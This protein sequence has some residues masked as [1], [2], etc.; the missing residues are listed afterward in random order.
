[1]AM[2][3]LLD[4]LVWHTLFGP[5]ARYAAGTDTARRYAPGFPPIIGFSDV[6]NPDFPSLIPYTETGEHLY[7]DGWAGAVPSGWRIE[8]ESAMRTMMW[9]ASMPVADDVPEAVL[10]GSQHASAV[11]ELTDLIRP[12]PFGPR[13]IELGEYIGVFDGPRLVAMVGGRLCAGGFGEIGSV[14]T[15]PDFRGRGLARRL[16]VSL[17]RR[18]MQRGETPVLRVLR[19]NDGAH[20]LYRRMG[21]RDV[22]E[23]VARVVSRC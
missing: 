5:H 7:C 16:V 17:V 22:R 20:R 15:H 12:G 8:F 3:H 23:S 2:M 11:L 6:D 4:N 10:L 14:C 18:Q 1:M 13:T 19:D 9:E 21:F